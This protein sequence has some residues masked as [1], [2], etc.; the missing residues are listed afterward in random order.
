MPAGVLRLSPGKIEFTASLNGPLE[1]RATEVR[2]M[3]DSWGALVVR[4]RSGPSVLIHPARLD[5]P[6]ATVATAL[7]AWMSQAGTEVSTA[8]A[9]QTLLT[10]Q[11]QS[12]IQKIMWWCAIG[13]AVCAVLGKVLPMFLGK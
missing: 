6:L 3:V 4:R 5:V 13:A 8:F 10:Q 12:R 11:R 1:I 9:N 7:S 2:D